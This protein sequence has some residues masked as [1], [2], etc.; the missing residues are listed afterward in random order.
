MQNQVGKSLD[1]DLQRRVG[2]IDGLAVTA[3]AFSTPMCRWRARR[4]FGLAA[5]RCIHNMRACS[6]WFDIV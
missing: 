1:A 5:L 4:T 6:G 3:T 2:K